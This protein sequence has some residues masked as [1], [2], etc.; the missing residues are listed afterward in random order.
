MA[1]LG[2]GPGDAGEPVSRGTLVRVIVRGLRGRRCTFGAHC[3][4]PDGRRLLLDV[5]G[6]AGGR[7]I[8]VDDLIRWLENRRPQCRL[9]FHEGNRH[10]LSR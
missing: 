2:G 9:R 6:G 1:K 4:L 5:D 10:G 7:S 8:I 3:S